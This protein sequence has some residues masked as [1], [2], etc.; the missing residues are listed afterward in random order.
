MSTRENL[1]V[2]LLDASE[3]GELQTIRE[4]VEREAIDPNRIVER[5][6]REHPSLGSTKGCTPLH[7]ACM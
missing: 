3:R 2:Q 4:L 7:Y 1:E 5:R 6:D